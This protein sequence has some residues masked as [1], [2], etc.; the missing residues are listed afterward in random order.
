MSLNREKIALIVVLLLFAVG[1]YGVVLGFLAPSRQV[2]V[3][4]VS[5]TR[6][7]SQPYLPEFRSHTPPA[8]SRR[9]PFRLSEGWE[10]LDLLPLSPPALSH[11]ARVLPN[12]SAGPQPTEGGIWFLETAPVATEGA[13]GGD[14]P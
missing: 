3:P 9:N 5:I 4:D 8:A 1:I 14:K 2:R 12:L 11:G 6:L 13:T 7:E 10:S